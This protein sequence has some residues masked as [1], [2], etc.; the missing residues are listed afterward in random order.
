MPRYASVDD[1]NA[2][3]RDAQITITNT[4]IPST[5]QAESILEQV[6][7]EIHAYLRNRTQLPATDPETTQLLKSLAVSLACER[8]F[9]LAYPQSQLN[10]FATEARAA[11]ELLKAIAKGDAALPTTNAPNP[12][13]IA[14]LPTNEPQFK[15]NKRL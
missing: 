3:L 6:E 7:G 4:S 5:A 13:P 2:R 12:A 10:P 11:R 15:T 14:H 8:I 1:L 9:T